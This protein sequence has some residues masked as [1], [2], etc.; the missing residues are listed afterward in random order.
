[1][2]AHFFKTNRGAFVQ[3]KT[4]EWAGRSVLFNV[5]AKQSEYWP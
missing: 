4:S 1:M 2:V 5:G 3:K